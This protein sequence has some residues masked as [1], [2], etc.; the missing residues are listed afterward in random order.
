MG[1]IFCAGSVG[2]VFFYVRREGGLSE[3]EPAAL[4]ICA[5]RRDAEEWWRGVCACRR[6]TSLERWGRPSLLRMALG[7][8]VRHA[9]D[10]G[11]EGIERRGSVLGEFLMALLSKS[12]ELGVLGH[13]G[14]KAGQVVGLCLAGYPSM[15]GGDCLNDRK[16]LVDMGVHVSVSSRSSPR[17][18]MA[19]R[20][21][22]DSMRLN[23]HC[24]ITTDEY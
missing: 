6:S 20:F 2:S 10:I 17:R 24:S 9:Q 7:R 3:V 16:R 13:G 23:A 19:Q 8:S 22:S 1:A 11:T 21:I 4:G 14:G 15:T 12:R 18:D 5:A